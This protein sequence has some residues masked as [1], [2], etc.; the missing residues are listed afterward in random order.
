MLVVRRNLPRI[1]SARL[2]VLRDSAVTFYRTS[3][4]TAEAQ[5]RRRRAELFLLIC[6]LCLTDAQAGTA[7]SI[8]KPVSPEAAS[9][10][11]LAKTAEA[12]ADWKTAE[13]EYREALR[14]A[15]DW[16]EAL[17]NL[18]IVCN[19]QGKTDEALAAFNRAA[20]IN[21]RLVGAQLN[22]AITHFRT[23]RFREA[24]IPL[25]RALTIE[26]E[27][28]QAL[29]LLVLTLF[30]LEQYNEVTELGERVLKANA[31]DAPTL[32]VTGRAYLKL[33]RY[34]DAVRLLETCSRLNPQNAEILML[35]GEARDNAGDTEGALRDFRTALSVGG[36]SPP[37]ELHFALGYV[38]WKL[39]KYDEAES[40][41][42]SEIAHNPDH[43]RSI[44]YLGNIAVVRGDWKAA[45]PL[46][47]RAAAAMP[48]S[49][50]AHYD[51]GKALLRDGQVTQAASELQKAIA[52]NAKNSSAHYQ[53]ALAYRQMKREDEA[54]REFSLAR[55]LNKLERDELEKKV[56]GEELKKK[57]F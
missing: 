20:E 17:V 48:Q 52:V 9:H 53:L 31:T 33:R 47:E 45:L 26:P 36:S 10:F 44:Y 32:E 40:A 55:E 41:F 22:I 14:L 57:P 4:I 42:R 1:F 13:S 27:N 38:L 28:K 43:P 51:F 5:S 39:R 3:R 18:G 25:R 29:G 56:Q 50:D 8:Q 12:R 37:A 16:A 2:C 6:I 54:Q 30:A 23:K 35:L 21:P 19:R 7:R 49:F 34:S 46:L 11:Q 24:E 15:P